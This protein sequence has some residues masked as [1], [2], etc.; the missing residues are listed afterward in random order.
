LLI[1]AGFT[2]QAQLRVVSG[3]VTSLTDGSTLPGVTVQIKGTNEGSVSDLD[4]NFIISL[5]P[6]D[7]VVFSF[8]GFVSQEVVYQ[9]QD[10]LNV[11]MSEDLKQLDE[12][13]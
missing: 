13:Q 8:V 2:G 12:I 6:N 11:Q 10:A 1:L 7:V 5:D 3:K 9:G 4:G